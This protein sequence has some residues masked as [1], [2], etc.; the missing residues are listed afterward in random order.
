M[1]MS[2]FRLLGL[3]G[4]FRL[5]MKLM[6]DRRVPLRLKLLMPAALVYLVSPID[7]LPDIIPIL[8]HIDDLIVTAVALAIFLAMSPREVVLEHFRGRG[9]E[10]VDAGAPKSRENVIEGEYHYVEDEASRK[11]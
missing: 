9:G 3:T 10:P 2:I 6:L 8:G 5:V 11:Q 1:A 7:P 4:V